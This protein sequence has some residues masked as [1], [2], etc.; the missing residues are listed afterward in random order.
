M[1]AYGFKARWVPKLLDGSKLT[2]LRADRKDGRA[3]KVG[4]KF[5]A[6]VGMRTKGCRR[7][8]DSVTSQL[9]RIRIEPRLGESE[10]EPVNYAI[11]CD[12]RMLSTAQGEAMA[13]ADG[14]DSLEDFTRFF[15][16]EHSIETKIFWGW[17]ITWQPIKPS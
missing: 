4:E 6:F 14:F 17:L 12:G 10:F 1:S 2:T 5:S 9:N 3:P 13:R 8:F 16:E 11:F 7:L 15:E